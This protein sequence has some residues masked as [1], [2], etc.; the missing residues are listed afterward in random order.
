MDMTLSLG[1]ILDKT[2]QKTPSPAFSHK[3]NSNNHNPV[4]V[5]SGIEHEWFLSVVVGQ[6]RVDHVCSLLLYSLTSLI[7][8]HIPRRMDVTLRTRSLFSVPFSTCT[9]LLR[10]SQKD[11]PWP[12]QSG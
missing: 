1:D 3:K 5:L 10:T 7:H 12:Y 6:W 9:M 8:F 11:A 4:A 2:K